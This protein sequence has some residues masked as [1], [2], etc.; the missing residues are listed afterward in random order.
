MHTSYTVGITTG[1]YLA[2][3]HVMIDQHEWIENAVK[4]RARVAT[5]EIINLYS[6]YK[7]N[8]GETITAIGT[9]NV[10]QAAYD[11]GVIKK[12]G[13]WPTYKTK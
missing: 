12:R 7:I 11:E 6:Q 2:L 3:D 5:I 4:E 8:K 9:T 10:I 1:E 13:T